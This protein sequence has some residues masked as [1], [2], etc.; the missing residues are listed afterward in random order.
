MQYKGQAEQDKYV[1]NVLKQKKNG[2][3][4]EIGSNHPINI[5]N[6]YILETQFN[7]KGIMIDNSPAWLHLYKKL[8][9]NSIHVIQDATNI[10]YAELLKKSNFPTN[11]D[12][13]QV[14]IEP[15]NGSTLKT[16]QKLD[17]DILDNYKFATVTFEHDCKQELTHQAIVHETRK[18]SREIFEKRGYFLLFEDINNGAHW[19]VFE[20]W[21][22]HP[23]L[24]DMNYINQ[25]VEKNAIHYQENKL[26]L[27]NRSISFTDIEY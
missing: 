24:V 8:R 1:I 25:L 13:L 22:V 4:L 7:W 10:D 14:D 20:D 6:T 17:D 19:R 2:Y 18:K 16:I 3:F 5:N 15:S 27:N 21:Y 23:D 26:G 9:P 11:L 12:Y